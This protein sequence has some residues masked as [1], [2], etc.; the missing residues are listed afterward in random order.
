MRKYYVTYLPNNSTD[1]NDIIW[2]DIVELKEDEK[3]NNNLFRDKIDELLNHDNGYYC[4]KIIA[5][6]LIEE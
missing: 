3:A 4:L 5:W 6:S 1:V 2:E